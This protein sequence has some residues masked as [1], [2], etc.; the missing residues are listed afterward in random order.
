MNDAEIIKTLGGPT[1]L[2]RRLGFKTPDGA[3][4]VHNWIA[5]GIPAKVKLE[6]PSIFREA[7]RALVTKE[8]VH[9]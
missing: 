1:V 3:R 2:A 7:K 9:G 8:V 5:R 4:R 6:H